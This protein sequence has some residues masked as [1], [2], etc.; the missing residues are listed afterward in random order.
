V[1]CGRVAHIAA[2]CCAGIILFELVFLLTVQSTKCPGWDIATK[3]GTSTSIWSFWFMFAL[4]TVNIVYHAVTW[5]RQAEKLRQQIEWGLRTYVPGKSP[6]HYFSEQFKA[7]CAAD[8][9]YNFVIVAVH[10][11]SVFFVLIPLL[12]MASSCI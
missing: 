10:V 3:N 2:I 5:Q 12:I 4:W 8:N 7:K 9:N 11:G 1:F 6:N